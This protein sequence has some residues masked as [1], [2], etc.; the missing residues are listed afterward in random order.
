DLD[1][2]IALPQD[3]VERLI[4]EAALVVRG[5]DDGKAGVLCHVY[6]EILRASRRNVRRR[7]AERLTSCGNHLRFSQMKFFQASR[8]TRRPGSTVSP[9]AQAAPWTFV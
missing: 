1:V 7:D 9:R 6:A 4:D 2:G 3:A 5:N 8:A